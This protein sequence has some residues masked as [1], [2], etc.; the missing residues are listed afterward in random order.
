MEEPL[1]KLLFRK[2]HPQ[3]KDPYKA[4]PGDAGWDLSS[5]DS[6]VIRPRQYRRIS[7]GIAVAVPAGFHGLITAR[8]STWEKCRLQVIDSRIDS[9]FRGELFVRVWNPSFWRWRKVEAGTRIGQL[10]VISTP[11][12]EAV[13]IDDLPPA[14]RG[15]KGVGSSG[16]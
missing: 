4:Y 10:I 11:D 7:T 12:I 16:S 2:N 6:A 14:E 1:K 3:S 9:G 13:E 15:L 5:L 8:S